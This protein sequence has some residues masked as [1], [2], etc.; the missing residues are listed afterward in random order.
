MYHR[1]VIRQT[2][3]WVFPP[4]LLWKCLIAAAI[5]AVAHWSRVPGARGGDHVPG[6]DGGGVFWGALL[7]RCE[8]PPGR[9]EPTEWA[10][11]RCS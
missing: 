11:R 4:S 1:P 5:S 6:G 2:H 3:G 7:G 10:S 9:E 8:S